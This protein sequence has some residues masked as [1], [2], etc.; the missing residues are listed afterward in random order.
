MLDIFIYFIGINNFA[1][2]HVFGSVMLMAYSEILDAV[3]M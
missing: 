2:I 1:L 3:V